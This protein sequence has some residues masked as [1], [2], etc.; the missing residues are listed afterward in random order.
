MNFGEPPFVKSLSQL[1]FRYRLCAC[2]TLA[3]VPESDSHG[4]Y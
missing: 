2:L 4:G 3:K 1:E